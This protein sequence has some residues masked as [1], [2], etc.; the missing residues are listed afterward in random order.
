MPPNYRDY[1]I[2]LAAVFITMSIIAAVFWFLVAGDVRKPARADKLL[3]ALVITALVFGFVI[4]LKRNAWRD[5]RFWLAL[6]AIL[7]LLAPLQWAAIRHIP[8]SRSLY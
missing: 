5:R 4:E 7:V 1:A 2:Y 8:T 6:V 3:D